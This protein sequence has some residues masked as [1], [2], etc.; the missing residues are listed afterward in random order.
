MYLEFD[1]RTAR[2][3]LARYKAGLDTEWAEYAIPKT[4][5]ERARK[6]FAGSALTEKSC[7]EGAAGLV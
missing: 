2:A 7:S 6:L 4:N 3:D 5:A 1:T